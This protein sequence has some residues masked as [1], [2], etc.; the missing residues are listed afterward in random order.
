MINPIMLYTAGGSVLLGLALGWTVRDWKADSDA[1]DAVKASHKAQ[2][3]LLD[4]VAEPSADLENT[5]ANLRTTETETRNTIKEVYRNVEVP[6]NCAVPADAVRVLVDAVRDANAAAAG[7]L[8]ARVQN[9]ATPAA[10][11]DRP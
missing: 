2:I 11:A 1:L 9:T 8:G 7:E 3:E 5:I 6:A 4:V 10:A